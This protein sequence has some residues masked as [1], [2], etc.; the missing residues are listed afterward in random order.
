MWRRDHTR[1]S[2]RSVPPAPPAAFTAGRPT[3]APQSKKQ[4]NQNGIKDRVPRRSGCASGH[5]VGPAVGASVP[6]RC[7]KAKAR[8]IETPEKPVAFLASLVVFAEITS[9]RYK[10]EFNLARWLPRQRPSRRRE[11]K[12]RAGCA[13]FLITQI[14]LCLCT[15]T[16]T[17]TTGFFTGIAPLTPT[18]RVPAHGRPL[19]LVEKKLTRF[20][21]ASTPDFR[22]GHH[23]RSLF[24]ALGQGNCRVKCVYSYMA[25]IVLM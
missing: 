20:L 17:F 21:I 4:N 25:K 24:E 9:F 3:V 14:T 5:L 10:W 1:A 22:C 12:K 16:K 18:Y 23:H 13:H 8:L 19:H 15:E 6:R 11:T 2:H 7:G